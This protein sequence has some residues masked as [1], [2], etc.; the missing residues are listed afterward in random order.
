MHSVRLCG[1]LQ[2]QR[3]LPVKRAQLCGEKRG[4]VWSLWAPLLIIRWQ[5]H[6]GYPPVETLI[7]EGFVPLINCTNATCLCDA[8]D[9]ARDYTFPPLS[10]TMERNFNL[11][12]SLGACARHQFYT[13]PFST[14][15]VMNPYCVSNRTGLA[16]VL[17]THMATTH[18]QVRYVTQCEEVQC[19][20]R[21]AQD[22]NHACYSS[23]DQYG[24]FCQ[25]RDAGC[26]WSEV[27]TGRSFCLPFVLSA[28][29]HYRC[30]RLVPSS[31]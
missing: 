18:D 24:Y 30:P 4:L 5:D 29:A 25:A 26:V 27:I 15:A 2:R 6:N 31:P 23:G 12:A 13:L 3:F 8:T 1:A 7:E 10:R 21:P 19:E 22:G 11:T 9:P 17:T 28:L 20:C 14:C 16:P